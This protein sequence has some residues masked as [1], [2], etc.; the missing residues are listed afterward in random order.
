M[1]KN[2]VPTPQDDK[3]LLQDTV[4][5]T[6]TF[7]SA[8]IDMGDGYRP[9]SIGHMCAGVVKV[10]SADR[11]S[12][13]ETYVF[14]LQETVADA[15]GVA[16]DSKAADIGPTS[17]VDVA[18]AVATLGI[19]SVGGI[20]SQRFVRLVATLAGTTPSVTYKAWLNFNV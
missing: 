20:L 13:D 8:W 1:N 16:D 17:A 7:S 14:K 3:M 12:S 6:A 10:T 19:I 4:T 2:F 11:T 9:G 5:K 18:A 15:N